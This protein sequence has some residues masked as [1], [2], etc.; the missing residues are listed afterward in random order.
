M[1]LTFEFF[2]RREDFSGKGTTDCT[3]ITDKKEERLI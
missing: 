2:A 3:D 1:L